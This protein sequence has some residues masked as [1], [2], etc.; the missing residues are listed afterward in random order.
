MA[1]KMLLVCIIRPNQI[2]KMRT[3]ATDDPSICVSVCH[4]GGLC[5][6]GHM[7]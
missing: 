2:Y 4:M 7:E 5:K 3:V 6:N 1:L